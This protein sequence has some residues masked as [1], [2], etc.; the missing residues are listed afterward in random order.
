M[1]ADRFPRERRGH[2]LAVNFAGGNV[3]TLVVPLLAVT[4]IGAVG[5]QGTM[6]VFAIP[7]IVVGLLLI[8]ALDD[9][10]RAL[11]QQGPKLSNWGQLREVL[12]NRN[13]VVLIGAAS[14]AAGGR[15]L[16]VLLT[17]V[18]LYLINT[19]GY[20]PTTVGVLYTV[21]LLGSVAGPMLAGQASD[22]FGRKAVLLT[23]LT[24][25]T[26]TTILLA[27][28]GTP[29]VP[30][31]ALLLFL[32]GAFVFV[33]SPVIQSYMADS[34][35]SGKRDVLFGFYFAWVYA[36]GAIW[37]TAIGLVVD[38]LGF[39]SAWLLMAASYLGAAL[40]VLQSREEARG[41]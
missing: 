37:L 13:V 3:G 16:G 21:M 24:L 18:P 1:I 32:M 34:V 17:F 8:M 33:E 11:P 30:V 12:A 14:I 25:S 27:A 19:L 23:S 35:A 22:R 10:N 7:G 38:K 15:G 6:F 2:A 20:P 36:V 31:L 9:R 28:S 5:W 39:S 40:F 4:L 26:V 41:L 29:P